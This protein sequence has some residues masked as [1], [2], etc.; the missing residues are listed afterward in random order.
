MQ[1][2]KVLIADQDHSSFLE[3]EKEFQNEDKFQPQY[4]NYHASLN[5]NKIKQYN[6]DLLVLDWTKLNNDHNRIVETIKQSC[7]SLPIYI[8]NF[9][10]RAVNSLSTNTSL[11]PK[12]KCQIEDE[13]IRRL[14]S[15]LRILKRKTLKDK[16][17]FKHLYSKKQ[18]P[19]I[20]KEYKLK[21]NIQHN[22]HLEL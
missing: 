10:G 9:E 12:G 14:R 20:S 19:S 11:I 5:I 2:F 22:S 4:L 21:H 7:Q 17:T 13:R 8:T 3:V 15:A 16:I 1:P 18:A 6:P